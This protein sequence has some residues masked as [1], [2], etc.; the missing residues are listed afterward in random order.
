VSQQNAVQSAREYLA[1]SAF[2]RS[3]LI[4]QLEYEGFSAGDATA[5]VDSLAVDWNDQAAKSA[6]EYLATSSFSRSGLISQLEY[7][8]FTPAQ[9]QYGVSQ[10]GL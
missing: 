6:K 8:G 2:S 4:K 7:E 10:T 1:T 5:A 3:G 9:A